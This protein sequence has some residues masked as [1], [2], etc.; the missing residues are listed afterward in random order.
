M[1]A[2]QKDDEGEIRRPIAVLVEQQ[3]ETQSPMKVVEP[4]QL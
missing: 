3:R 4:V 2:C 1:A